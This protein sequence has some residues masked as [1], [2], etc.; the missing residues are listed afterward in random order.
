[1][2]EW[3]RLRQIADY[4]FGAGAGE[5]LFGEPAA[6]TVTRSKSGRPRQVQ[7]ADGR[8]VSLGLDGRFTLGLAGG[9]RLREILDAPSGRV[10]VGEESDPFVREGRN[11]FAKFVLDVGESIRSAD[12]VLVVREDDTLLG[13][14]R[15]E[16]PAAA[17][18]D[19][20]SGVAV[21]V[22]DGAGK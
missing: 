16:L 9:R 2:D 10:V 20:A 13:V 21:S 12:E 22:R 19:L 6:L 8:L 18:A 17:M 1:M 11:A 14:G 3:T 7:A 5:A 4:Q 15:A